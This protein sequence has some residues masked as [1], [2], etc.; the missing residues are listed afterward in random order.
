MSYDSKE[1]SPPTAHPPPINF[2]HIASVR[3]V[4]SCTLEID[5]RQPYLKE[6]LQGAEEDDEVVGDVFRG[7]GGVAATLDLSKKDLP[8]AL[9][10]HTVVRP[11]RAPVIVIGC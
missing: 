10:G 9:T 5:G 6:N 11:S 3:L 1:S 7:C 4:R 2:S 8:A